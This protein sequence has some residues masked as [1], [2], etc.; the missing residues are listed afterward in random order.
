MVAEA[1]SL[2]RWRA[3]EKGLAFALTY[4][5]PLPETITTDPTRVRQI[6]RASPYRGPIKDPDRRVARWKPTS[7]A[8]ATRRVI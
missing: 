5:S 3:E 8:N 6:L 2:M 1:T 7:S 4:R